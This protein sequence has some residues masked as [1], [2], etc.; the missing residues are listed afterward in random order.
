MLFQINLKRDLKLAKKRGF[1]ISKLKIVVDKLADGLI[2]EPK[3]K[4]HN[5]LGEYTGYRECHIEPNWLLVY[6]I[7]Q[8]ELELF[9][10]R[11]GTHS[12]LF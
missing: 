6:R 4:D 12:E 9:L 8:A 5:L 2:L 10:F 1:D 11:N 7:D 3:Y